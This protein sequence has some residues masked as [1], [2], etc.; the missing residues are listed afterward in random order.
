MKSLF[1][2]IASTEPAHVDSAPDQSAP[3]GVSIIGLPDDQASKLR[4]ILKLS[5]TRAKKYFEIEDNL[6]HQASI[7][8]TAD[9]N[10]AANE[11]QSVVY[12][13]HQQSNSAYQLQPPLMSIRVLRVLDGIEVKH[14]TQNRTVAKEVALDN[15]NHA[16]SNNNQPQIET[17]LPATSAAVESSDN[18][19]DVLSYRVLIVDDSVLIHKALDIE[20]SKAPFIPNT[21]YAESGEDCLKLVGQNQYDIIFLDVMMPGIDGFET[22]TEIRKIASY[23]KVPIIMLSAKTSP[24]DEVKGVMAGCTTYLTK[25]IQHEAFQKLLNRMGNWLENYKST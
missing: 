24:L 22:C 13:G 12:Y 15:S 8:I 7:I 5:D 6:A 2:R 21:D 11:H 4:R 10:T 16:L 25:P 9:L 17:T 3:I 18:N 1:K 19:Q 20:L 23:K 14:S